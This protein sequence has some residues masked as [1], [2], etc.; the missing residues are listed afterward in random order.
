MNKQLLFLTVLYRLQKPPLNSLDKSVWGATAHT[1]PTPSPKSM[2]MWKVKENGEKQKKV[3]SE[4]PDTVAWVKNCKKHRVSPSPILLKPGCRWNH[5]RE[6]VINRWACR[7]RKGKRP[8]PKPPGTGISDLFQKSSVWNKPSTKRQIL[9]DTSYMRLRKQSNYRHRKQNAGCQGDWGNRGVGEC[10][11]MG[12]VSVLQNKRVLEMKG[13][14]GR[15]ILW[16]YL[17]PLNYH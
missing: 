15:T 17:I 5:V 16:M 8:C 12:T 4:E 1:P 11:L 9:H 2:F 3:E 13:G 14:D 7:Y 10:C 6:L